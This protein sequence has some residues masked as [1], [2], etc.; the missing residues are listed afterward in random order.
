MLASTSKSLTL[1]ITQNALHCSVV[2]ITFYK[3]DALKENFCIT[4]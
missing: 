2:I 4:C 1:I 3:N